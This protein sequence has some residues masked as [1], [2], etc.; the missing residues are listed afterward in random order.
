MQPG[1]VP[2]KWLVA[3][4]FVS[5]LFMD[6]MDATVVN[7]ALPTLGRDF[8]AGNAT[9]EWVVTGYLLSLAVWIPASGWIGDR[10]GTKKTFLFALGMFTGASVLCG[11]AWNIESLIAFRVLQGVGGGM[12]TPVGTAML[13][14]AFPPQERAR[15]S[16]VLAVPTAIAPAVGPV[17]GGW[18]VDQASWR[19]IFYVNLPVG[20]A[21]FAFA[22]LFLRE[23]TEERAG[24]FDLPGFVFSGAGLALVLYALS[25]GPVD[26]WTAAGVLATGSGGV[27]LFVLLIVVELRARAPMLDLRLFADRMFRTANLVMF[28]TMGV[29]LG[30]LFLLPL[31]LQQLRGLSALES[32]LT[33][34]PQALGMIVTVRFSSRLYPKVGPRRM[35]LA[36]V[37]GLTVTS[38]L[39]LLVGLETDLWWIRGIMFLRGAA[40]AFSLVPMQAATFATIKSR[41]T[42]RAS[43]LFN[44]N[45]Q[46]ASSVGVA[47]LATVL[48][49]RT[50]AHVGD[51]GAAATD[52][53][54]RHATLLAFHDAFAASLVLGLVGI[55]FTFLIRDADAAASMRRA[56][57]AAHAEAE[58]A[59]AE[60][61]P[62]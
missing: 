14:R 15:A 7:V 55:A 5:A 18:L 34:F 4:A 32:G 30:V 45:R 1:N 21:A 3:V 16:A 41:D 56:P 59:R 43:S 40:M 49:E 19:W 58:S 36:G 50:A 10:F 53:A 46:V 11:A 31:F 61:V 57:A 62:I 44:T 25:R 9:I 6:I 33:T 28:M 54:A 35:M 51:L 38:A 22:L 23:H 13:F 42:G 20:V 37:L 12:L 48:V 39:F 2:Y 60:S 29:F 24:R 26:G 8:R 27:L 52:E 47:L 17:F